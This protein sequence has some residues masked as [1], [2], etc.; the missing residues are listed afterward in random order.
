MAQYY[1]IPDPNDINGRPSGWSARWAGIASQMT[2]LE[3][4]GEHYIRIIKNS[5]S[6]AAYSI[7]AI[8]AA[9]NVEVFL[10]CLYETWNGSAASSD[11]TDIR[12]AIRGSGSA[13]S[14]TGYVNGLRPQARSLRIN[15]YV[16][17]N[18]TDIANEASFD[19]NNTMTRIY[20]RV[21]SEGDLHSLKAWLAS[22]S[23]PDVW[24]IQTTD[25]GITGTG[26]TGVFSI[27]Q[28]PIR[29]YRWGIGTDGDP[30]PTE[31]VPVGPTT[32]T[33]LITSN[34]TANSFRAG[35]TP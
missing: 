3:D 23:E 11:A 12:A 1:G 21:R 16:N 28:G 35:W 24:D 26:W 14:E 32:P 33:G 19:E 17:G 7:D 15:R 25:G 30:A 31:P 10:D 8:P 13:S 9:Q 2:V 18:F 6:R 22:D 27:T 34:I 4:T 5:T 20:Q 29:I